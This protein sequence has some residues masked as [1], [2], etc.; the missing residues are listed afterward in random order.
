MQR[1][2]KHVY[3][4][5]PKVPLGTARLLLVPGPIYGKMRPVIV[6][7]VIHGRLVGSNEHFAQIEA[8]VL[9]PSAENDTVYPDTR[10][11]LTPY[12]QHRQIAS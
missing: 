4:S 3:L 10:R 1:R 6:G 5:A 12:S 7:A 2:G 11:R 8:N 9:Q